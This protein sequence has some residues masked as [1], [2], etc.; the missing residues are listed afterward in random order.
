MS[1]FPTAAH[2]VSWAKLCP[3]TI[4][5]GAIQRAARPA[6]ATPTSKGRSARPPPRP[7]RPTPSSANATGGSSNAA[8]NSKPSSLSP[9]PS[10]SSSG[11]CSS[12][13]SPLPRPRRR[14]PRHPHQ[15][16]TQATQPHR[17][18]GRLGLPRHPR[19]R[20][21]TQLHSPANPTRLSPGTAAGL[22]TRLF[23]GQATGAETP[24]PGAFC[25]KSP[26]SFATEHCRSISKKGCPL[27]AGPFVVEDQRPLP[28][29]GVTEPT[30]A[31]C[32][33]WFT[34]SW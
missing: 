32:W 28:K 4:Q 2:L 8:A 31:C 23:S 16:R 1:R 22:V 5:S 15:H 30:V 10:W 29:V 13:P 33:M 34:Q 26:A 18:T 3:R 17:A 6:R 27:Y 20:R 24:P 21:L 9:A 14:L 19:T 12:D 25:C 11:T 7:P